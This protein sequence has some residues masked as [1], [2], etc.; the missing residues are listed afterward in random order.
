MRCALIFYPFVCALL[1]VLMLLIARFW[2]VDK[3]APAV[4]KPPR[5]KR[6]HSVILT[7]PVVAVG[8]V[9]TPAPVPR[10]TSHS[11]ARASDCCWLHTTTPPSA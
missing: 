3:P 2:R 5:R 9:Q 6:E 4:P 1:I 11:V 10:Y 8:I 7:F